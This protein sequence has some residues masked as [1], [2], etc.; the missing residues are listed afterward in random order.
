[1]VHGEMFSIEWE[2]LILNTKRFEATEESKSSILITCKEFSY[3][4]VLWK[5]NLSLSISISSF[6]Y[7]IFYE[8]K[9]SCK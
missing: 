6:L 3:K 7:N 5:Y 9:L 4:S 8:T 2:T 1:M